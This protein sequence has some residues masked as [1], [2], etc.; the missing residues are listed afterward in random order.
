MAA[1][2]TATGFYKTLYDNTVGA[3]AALDTGAIDVSQYSRGL[4]ILYS[5]DGSARNRTLDFLDPSG[6]VLSRVINDSG[7]IPAQTS[8]TGT[9]YSGW[10]NPGATS[11]FIFQPPAVRLQIG[12]GTGGTSVRCIIYGRRA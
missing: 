12:A 6:A 11:P 9:A 4:I 3:G 2:L 7:V 5:T 10:G 1:P 8:G